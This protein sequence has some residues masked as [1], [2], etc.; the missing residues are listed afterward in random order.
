VRLN[1]ERPREVIVNVADAVFTCRILPADEAVELRRKHTRSRIS[2]GETV[3][4]FDASAYSEDFW[5]RIIVR[6]EGVENESGS[7][8]PC[9]RASKYQVMRRYAEIA[10]VINDAI[11]AERKRTFETSRELEKN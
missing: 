5:D 1:L 7:A 4:D 8:I 6:W 9:T 10:G 2:M 11:D 3:E